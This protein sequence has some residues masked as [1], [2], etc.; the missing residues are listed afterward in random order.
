[1]SIELNREYP[2]SDE[3][4][5][6]DTMVKLTVK[7]MK[8]QKG[9]M[10]RA[11]HAKATGC[12]RGLFTINSY[13]PED[14]RHGVFREEKKSFMAIARFSNSSEFLISDTKKDG[15][16]IAIKLLNIDGESA[17]ENMNSRTQD[18]L[19]VNHPVFPFATPAE[20]VK[21]FQ[22][23]ETPFAGDRLALAWLTLF[24][25]NH[26]KIGVEILNKVVFSPLEITYWSCSP[27]W[28]GSSEFIGGHAVKYSLVP[29]QN[30]IVLR[31]DE[32]KMPDDYLSLAFANFLRTQEAIF[33]FKVQ[34][35]TDPIKMPIEDTS[36]E[37]DENISKPITLATLTFSKQDVESQVGMSLSEECESMSFSPWNALIDHHPMGGIN[38]LRKAVYLASQ[39]HRNA[40]I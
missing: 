37:W 34:L 16:G 22:V 19:M 20:F 40:N 21:F 18:F 5:L 26:L 2:L 25:P 9:V 10:R 36:V 7:R 11:Q 13:V 6:I 31:K 4:E 32:L 3:A 1:M 38:R 12:A 29:K 39:K 28:L 35:Q 30:N 24:H 8:A 15:R 27:Y 33:D 14:L 17:I 23:R